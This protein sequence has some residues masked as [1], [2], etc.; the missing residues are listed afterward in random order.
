VRA[1]RQNP[2]PRY[3]DVVVN[4]FRTGHFQATTYSGAY[5]DLGA[6]VAAI[7]L[8]REARSATLDLDPTHGGLREPLVKLTSLMRSATHDTTRELRTR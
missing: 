2:S 6:A 7:L 3:I 1:A 8:D 5:G 4:A